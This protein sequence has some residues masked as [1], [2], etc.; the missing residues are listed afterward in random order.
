MEP[1]L[2]Y[3]PDADAVYVR[4]NDLPYA[5]GED[6]DHER[7]VDYAADGEPIGIELLNVSE[8]VDTRGLPCE[9]AV[10]RLIKQ[11]QIKILV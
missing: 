3:D 6:L 7:R 4:L 9:D 8:S 2:E 1:T 10:G 5:F 11:P